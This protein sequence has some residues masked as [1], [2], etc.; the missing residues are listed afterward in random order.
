MRGNGLLHVIQ[1]IMNCLVRDMRGNG[2]RNP[3]WLLSIK[4]EDRKML[5]NGRSYGEHDLYFDPGD[6][7]EWML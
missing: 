4:V 5:V 6:A 1:S 3:S 7:W 2:C